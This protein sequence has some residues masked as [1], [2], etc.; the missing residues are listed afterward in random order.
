VAEDWTRSEVEAIV[1]DYLT[2]LSLELQDRPYSKTDHRRHL[3]PLLNQRTD[4]S[5]ERKHQNISAVLIEVGFPYVSGYK[6][7][8]NYQQMLF[9]VVTDRLAQN[10]PLKP[11]A[12]VEATKL[13][14]A[15]KPPLNLL[16]L[17]VD[18]PL[19]SDKGMARAP[20]AEY[21][22]RARIGVDYLALEARNRSLGQAGEQLV[23]EFEAARLR[24]I[25]KPKLAKRIELVSA[26]RGDGAGFD[27]LS[28]EAS[29]RERF[30]EVKTTAFG[31]ETPFYLT[32]NELRFSID[33][34][35]EFHLYR[36]FQFR[37]DPR[38]FALSGRLDQTCL[39]DPTQYLARTA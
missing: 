29:G 1:D 13:A 9:D 34:K 36:L 30:I 18:P 2:M 22:V 16:S 28:F 20:T 27:V 32:R 8:R 37:R 3:K 10:H 14:D 7:L 17:L 33:H 11:L 4:G 5:I 21:T 35:T 15:L 25:G 12:E 31:K 6:P 38:L 19:P 24:R 26:T 23:I 39:L